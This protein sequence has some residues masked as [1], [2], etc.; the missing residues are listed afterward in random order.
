MMT[1]KEWLTL[2]DYSSKYRTSVSTL[3][4]RIKGEEVKYVF[5]NGKYF[6][7][8]LS[9]HLIVN[10]KK[11]FSHAP[12]K[13]EETTLGQHFSEKDFLGFEESLDLDF[14]FELKKDKNFE[15]EI[16]YLNQEKTPPPQFTRS[17]SS[18]ESVQIQ[19][20]LS[21]LLDQMN[22]ELK[23]AY[24]ATLQEK[25]EQIIILKEQVADLKTLINFLESENKRL[26]ELQRRTEPGLYNRL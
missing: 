7:P 12:P 9:P 3:R 1:T 11:S 4:R 5:E 17:Q 18:A 8:D 25:E 22:K 23:K 24:S 10:S 20:I 13:S 16:N 15:S 14:D 19:N 21:P 2:S 26:Q 6:L